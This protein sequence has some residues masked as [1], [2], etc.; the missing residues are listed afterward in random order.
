MR[1]SDLP[2]SPD[3]I[4]LRIPGFDR[5]VR[6][7]MNQLEIDEVEA[8]GFLSIFSFH[9]ALRCQRFLVSFTFCGY[10]SKLLICLFIQWATVSKVLGTGK[11]AILT[12][13]L[14]FSVLQ[15][16]EIITMQHQEANNN[17]K[18]PDS[19]KQ[20]GWPRTP[21]LFLKVFVSDNFQLWLGL[22]CAEVS[23]ARLEFICNWYQ[24]FTIALWHSLRCNVSPISFMYEA[25]VARWH[26]DKNQSKKTI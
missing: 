5:K 19:S 25:T 24:Q 1:E 13:H 8:R 9:S 17:K 15:F 2:N 12:A 3:I 10:T 16:L 11:L 18:T 4:W 22:H 21:Q 7:N 14:C 20:F 23:Y 6:G 26:L